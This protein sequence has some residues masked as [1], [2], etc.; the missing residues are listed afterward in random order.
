MS[1][2]RSFMY[3]SK[4]RILLVGNALDNGNHSHH[5]LQL[6]V[7]LEDRPFIVSHPNGELETHCALIRPNHDH[8]VDIVDTWRA[9]LLLDPESEQTRQIGDR[10]L[11]LKPVNTL[12][13]QDQLYCRSQLLPFASEQQAIE[14]THTALDNI[15]ETLSGPVIQTSKRDSRIEQVVEMIHSP[16]GKYAKLEHLAKQVHLSPSRLSHLFRQEMGLPIQRYQLWYKLCQTGYQV[17]AGTDMTTAATNAGFADTAHF[18]RTF[19]AMFGMT[20][21]QIMGRNDNICLTTDFSHAPIENAYED[22]LD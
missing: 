10:F 15:I 8:R 12:S 2:K 3:L 21:S 20:P 18:S 9:L 13:E 11:Q 16:A 1:N 6:T 7:S 22:A 4:G 14:D 5:A 17:L 19:K